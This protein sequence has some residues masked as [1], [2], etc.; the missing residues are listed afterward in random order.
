MRIKKMKRKESI[1]IT[2][3]LLYEMLKKLLNKVERMECLLKNE[4]NAG[5]KLQYAPSENVAAV[6]NNRE[7]EALMEDKME[8]ACLL[9]NQDVMQ[10][11]RISPRTLQTLRS[12][13]TLAY[14]RIRNKIYYIKSDV[15]QI[16]RNNY[17]MYKL[18]AHGKS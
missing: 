3:E 4:G 17:V 18:S 6:E 13:G 10:M 7:H 11:L 2:N 14:T 5:Q 1:V 15:E 16:L 12:N 9:D 8:G